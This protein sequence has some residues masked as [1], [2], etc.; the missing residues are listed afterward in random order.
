M[1]YPQISAS[2]GNL[3][4]SALGLLII[5]VF[6]IETVARIYSDGYMNKHI[7]HYCSQIVKEQL[8]SPKVDTGIKDKTVSRS[9]CS[10]LKLSLM[11]VISISCI[12]LT[13]PLLLSKGH[14]KS[15]S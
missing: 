6:S 2:A 15:L 8:E 3:H 7:V 9:V 14:G 10:E 1:D 5:C 4:G 12:T 13:C 11:L